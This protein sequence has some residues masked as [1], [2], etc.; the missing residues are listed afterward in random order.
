MFLVFG[1]AGLGDS[2]AGSGQFLDDEL[3]SFQLSLEAGD[4]DFLFGGVSTTD[5][6]RAMIYFLF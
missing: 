1:S 2:L 3:S 5:D 4:D 6:L